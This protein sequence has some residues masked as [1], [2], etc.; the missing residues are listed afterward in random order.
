[1]QMTLQTVFEGDTHSSIVWIFMLTL[2]FVSE[3]A[4]V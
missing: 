1:M 3:Q 4:A 2:A